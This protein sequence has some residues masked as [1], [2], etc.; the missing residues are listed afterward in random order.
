VKTRA[1]GYAA[2][3]NMIAIVY[4]IAGKL[5]HLPRNPMRYST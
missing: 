4:L 1:R 3:L 5:S 2:S